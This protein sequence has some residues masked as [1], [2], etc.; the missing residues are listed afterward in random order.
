V[1]HLRSRRGR[2]AWL[3][4]APDIGCP[5]GATIAL[6]IIAGPLDY[7]GLDPAVTC[8]APKPSGT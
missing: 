3:D 6:T 4:S 1:V 8:S 7:F 5:Q 2:P